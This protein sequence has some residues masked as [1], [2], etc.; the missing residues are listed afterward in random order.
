MKRR[1]ILVITK[2][3]LDLLDKEKELSIK[4]ISTKLNI[5]W[6]TAVKS[7]EFLK[8]INLITERRGKVTYKAE[9]LFRKNNI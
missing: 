3:I 6:E 1:G 9:R 8:N 2:D 4:S 5:R 7:L